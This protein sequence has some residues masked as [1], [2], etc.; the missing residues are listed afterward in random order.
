MLTKPD[1][2]VRKWNP[3]SSFRSLS[4][5][6][7]VSDPAHTK[8]WATTALR[9]NLFAV[10][11]LP[12]VCRRRC[13]GSM[14]FFFFFFF[15]LL[16]QSPE[17]SSGGGSRSLPF[18]HSRLLLRQQENTSAGFWLNLAVGT[19]HWYVMYPIRAHM[20][21][22]PLLPPPPTCLGLLCPSPATTQRWYKRGS[23]A[24]CILLPLLFQ[25]AVLSFTSYKPKTPTTVSTKVVLPFSEGLGE[26]GSIHHKFPRERRK[27]GVLLTT[28]AMVR[29]P[30][31]ITD[32]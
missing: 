10:P 24:I 9:K 6:F 13:K 23:L 17:P 5:W 12:W 31:G 1:V 32:F 29:A 26:G 2:I 18:S 27:V 15:F 11:L 14:V 7:F 21:L 16:P 25:I 28:W 20:Y 8:R 4:G 22:L 3:M 19:F 30:F